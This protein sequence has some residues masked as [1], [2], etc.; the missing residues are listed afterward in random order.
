[1]SAV[2]LVGDPADGADAATTVIHI[3]W[4]AGTDR[5]AGLPATYFEKVTLQP[6]SIVKKTEPAGER[7]MI[8]TLDGAR[9]A[10]AGK[11]ETFS[12]EFEDRREFISCAHG[13]MADKYFLSV[14]VTFSADGST[15]T[16]TFEQKVALGD[17]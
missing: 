12:L 1:M 5:G 4:D 14:T 7:E 3:A 15:A 17:Y 6:K 8:V 13:G 2:R 16:A 9:S 10:H 11:T